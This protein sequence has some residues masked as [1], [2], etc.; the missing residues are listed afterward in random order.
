MGLHQYA[1]CF[2]CIDL[3][4]ILKHTTVSFNLQQFHCIHLFLKKNGP[5]YLKKWCP[6]TRTVCIKVTNY[7]EFSVKVVSNFLSVNE[8]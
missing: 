8:C 7:K 3:L 1:I 6:Q 5:L 4:K 2:F